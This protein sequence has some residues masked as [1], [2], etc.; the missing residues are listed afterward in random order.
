MFIYDTN[1]R[2]H[3]DSVRV[4][5][6][7]VIQ[8]ISTNVDVELCKVFGKE[9]RMTPE[10]LGYYNSVCI[11]GSPSWL[12]HFPINRRLTKRNNNSCVHREQQKCWTERHG[13]NYIL[14][15]PPPP[16]THTHFQR[17]NMKV[18]GQVDFNSKRLLPQQHLPWHCLQ[19]QK[20]CTNKESTFEMREKVL[21]FI[22]NTSSI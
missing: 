19:Q 1:T 18:A 12:A 13:P 20:V 15:P 21:S 16:H 10:K 22:P 7:S 2:K 3:T 5:I 4:F 11:G 9:A 6:A 8:T 17:R 14:A